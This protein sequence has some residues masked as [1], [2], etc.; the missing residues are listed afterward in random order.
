MFSGHTVHE[1]RLR[2]TL[3][4]FLCRLLPQ[5]RISPF[6][7]SPG[8]SSSWMLE[9]VFTVAWSANVHHDLLVRC[10]LDHVRGLA[11]V[12]VAQPVRHHRIAVGQ[13]AGNRS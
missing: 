8:T 4:N 13:A 5:C 6:V 1:Y 10:H 12:A 2:A 11:E 9:I 3:S 7:A